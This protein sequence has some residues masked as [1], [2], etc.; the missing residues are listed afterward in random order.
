MTQE[1]AVSLKLPTFWTSQPQVWF[2]QAE[3]QFN[4][5]GITNDATRYYYVLSALDQS[6][7]ARLLDLIS[8]P[9]P[10][11]KYKTHIRNSRNRNSIVGSFGVFV[12][13]CGVCISWFCF[14]FCCCPFCFFRF[15]FW[16]LGLLSRLI[17]KAD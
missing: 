12:F 5:R 7:A 14:C 17:G 8:Q 4:I 16:F 10:D 3:A 9:P 2:A 6:I 15:V 11:D 1:H 13:V